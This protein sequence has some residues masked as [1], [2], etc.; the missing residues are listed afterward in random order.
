[1]EMNNSPLLLLVALLSA[2]VSAS[3]TEEEKTQPY[4]NWVTVAPWL[5][6]DYPARF[7]FDPKSHQGEDKWW[8]KLDDPDSDLAVEVS[9]FSYITGLDLLLTIPGVT[10]QNYVEKLGLNDPGP[11][12]PSSE[13]L[14]ASKATCKSAGDFFKVYILPKDSEATKIHGYERFIHRGKSEVK[15]YFLDPE[16]YKQISGHPFQSLR[17]TFPEG[18]YET[19]RK[20]ID[21]I[22]ASAKPSF[23]PRD[24]EPSPEPRF[25]TAKEA[26][27]PEK[28]Q[29][30]QMLIGDSILLKTDDGQLELKLL[31]ARGDLDP[32]VETSS[33]DWTFTHGETTKSG[34]LDLD[35]KSSGPIRRGD[36]FDVNGLSLLWSALGERGVFIYLSPGTMYSLKSS[37]TPEHDKK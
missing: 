3:A 24:T 33:F 9:S 17:F 36:R 10:G 1:M 18:K 22:I 6:I 20:T 31:A 7:T 35:I 5:H 2:L 27:G 28:R 15:V 23:H 26:N 19:H 4:P 12:E 30:I 8:A 25:E 16:A 14:I 29:S 32:Y 11:D 13:E 21:A 34:R 37:P